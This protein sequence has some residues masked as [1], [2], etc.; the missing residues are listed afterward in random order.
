MAPPSNSVAKTA[1]REEALAK[2]LNVIMFTTLVVAVLAFLIWNVFHQ[3][4]LLIH[5]GHAR[6]W[7]DFEKLFSA[8]GPLLPGI[9]LAA[10]WLYRSRAARR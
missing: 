1:S 6:H 3:T 4:E 8:V 10:S 5:L 7:R 2:L 9:A